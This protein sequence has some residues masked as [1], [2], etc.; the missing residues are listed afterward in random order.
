[1]DEKVLEQALAKF[2]GA[3]TAFEQKQVVRLDDL[4]ARVNDCEAYQVAG[5]ASHGS[6]SAKRRD[7]AELKA[8]RQ[9][10]AGGDIDR[11]VLESASGKA[12]SLGGGQDILAPEILSRNIERFEKDSLAL[13]QFVNRIRVSTGDYKINARTTPPVAAW[14]TETGSR[15]DPGD[16]EYRQITPVGG[17]LYGMI[18]AWNFFLQDA[19][20]PMETEWARDFAEQ[21]AR[22]LDSGIING[23]ASSGQIRGFLNTTPVTTADFASP[24][25]NA[26]A[27]QYIA[28]PSPDNLIDHMLDAFFTLNAAYRANAAW[29]MNSATLA[30]VRQAKDSTGQP[31]FQNTYGSGVDLAD[32]TLFGKPV[33]ISEYMPDLA[34]SPLSYPIAVGDWRAMYTLVEVGSPV[35]IR[36]PY[37]TKGQTKLYYA[38]RFLGGIVNNDAVKLLQ[39]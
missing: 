2:D 9:W 4:E 22:A 5:G 27:L 11:A 8:L 30:T 7:E 32:G 28:A 33:V 24:L 13:P 34:Q 35:V 23:T 18:S 21:R 26:N 25:R 16:P 37:T 31:V 15:S 38:S 10:A 29:L 1:M 12:L 14:V 3:I 6:N 36:D 17:E 19:Q 39:R 20:Y